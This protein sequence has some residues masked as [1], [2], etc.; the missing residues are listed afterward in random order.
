[1]KNK[2]NDQ[3]DSDEELY[4]S[5]YVEELE[6]AGIIVKSIY[7][8]PS[9]MVCPLQTISWMKELKTKSVIEESAFLFDLVYT[10]DWKLIWHPNVINRL[11]LVLKSLIYSTKSPLKIFPFIGQWEKGLITSFIDVKGGY[12]AF[13]NKSNQMFH[14]IQKVLYYHLGLYV[15]DIEPKELFTKTF[16]PNKYRSTPKLHRE[17]A[18]TSKLLTADQY[19]ANFEGTFQTKLNL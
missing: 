8:P 5:W 12:S 16:C 19:L 18:G 4:F 2:R 10:P 13:G 17:R 14:V 7:H 1:M 15:Q 11:V 9:I 3:F 6:T